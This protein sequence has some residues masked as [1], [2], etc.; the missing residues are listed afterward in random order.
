MPLPVLVGISGQVRGLVWTVPPRG[1][2]IGRQRGNQIRIDDAG[3]SRQHARIVLHE[4]AL[5][6]QDLGSRNGVFVNEAPVVGQQRLASGDRIV[7]GDHVLELRP[8][9]SSGSPASSAAPAETR[10]PSPPPAPPPASGRWRGWPFVLTG[11]GIL[12]LVLWVVGFGQE[13]V[14][15]P[16]RHPPDSVA[17]LLRSTSEPE[18]ERPIGIGGVV[19]DDA[20]PGP[21][22]EVLPPPEDALSSAEWVERGHQHYASG[23]LHEALSA[24]TRARAKDPACEICLR[25]IER[26]E[27]EIDQAIADR[28]DAGLSAWDDLQ[29]EQA[30]RAWEAVL[31]LSPDP[32][33]R[34]N[35]EAR[36]YLQEAE[37]KLKPEF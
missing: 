25:R 32:G 30:V 11:G 9:A 10:A 15:S 28:F 16:A 23:Q 21:A 37:R 3:V 12:L 26:L 13:Q 35:R 2:R 36:V 17:D 7:L 24:Y 14:R 20:P 4:G 18:P 31:L 27:R 22:E 6:I 34:A 33:S 5:W 8:P 19:R 1:L 29:Y